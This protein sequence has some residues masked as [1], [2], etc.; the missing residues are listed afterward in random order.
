MAT[1]LP[2]P[3]KRSLSGTASVIAAGSYAF[4]YI[5]ESHA[6]REE[7][8]EASV[9]AKSKSGET[10]QPGAVQ[11]LASLPSVSSICY[12]LLIVTRVN[13]FQRISVNRITNFI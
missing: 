4:V 12:N 6:A 3:V 5:S 11:R 7:T 9:K 10:V 13:F 8:Q 2:S 1:N